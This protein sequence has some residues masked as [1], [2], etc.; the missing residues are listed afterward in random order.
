[1]VRDQS[2]LPSDV[3]K[4][5]RLDPGTKAESGPPESVSGSKYCKEIEPSK[6]RY[7]IRALDGAAKRGASK[8]LP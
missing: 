2:V 3:D 1:M 7:M 4:Q 8:S 6:R 5:A